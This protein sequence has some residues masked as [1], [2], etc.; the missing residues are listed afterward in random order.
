MKLK[1]TILSL[2]GTVVFVGAVAANVWA[3]T[4]CVGSQC[5][6]RDPITNGCDR[7]VKTIGQ[8][9]TTYWDGIF[10]YTLLIELKYSPKC[11]AGWVKANRVMRNSLIILR[12]ANNKNL[13]TTTANVTGQVFGDMWEKSKGLKACV[14]LPQGQSRPATVC[15]SAVPNPS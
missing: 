4:G 7:D 1:N 11:K 8:T 5:N 14:S 2:A 15:T 10:K 3:Q 6:G 12:D 13:I 9:S